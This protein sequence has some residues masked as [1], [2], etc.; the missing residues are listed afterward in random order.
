MFAIALLLPL[1]T[2]WNLFAPPNRSFKIGPKLAGVTYELPLTLSWSAIRDGS[3]QKAIA[4]RITEAFA[5]RPMLIRINNEIRYELFGEL[6]APGLVR[7]AKGHLFGQYYIDDYCSRT[8][9]M[10]ERLAADALP[11]LRD[12]RDY[13]RARGGIF[14]YMVSPSKAAHLPDYFTDR[15][16]CPSTAAD[17]AQLLP[18]Y[19]DA[20]RAGG[21]DVLDAASL[22]HAARGKYPFDLFPEGG[23]HWNEVGGALAVTSLVEEINKQAEREIVP[24][25]TFSYELSSPAKGADRELADLLNVFF[26]PL[27]YLTPK[28]KYTQPVSCAD[29]SAR[30][31]DIAIVGDSFSHLPGSILAEQNCLARL[32]VYYYGKTGLF[33]GV[34]Y[35]VLKLNLGDADLAPLRDV[36]V[37]I[38]E[39]NERFVARSGYLPMLRDILKR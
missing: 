37:L 12:I 10:G 3:L 19:T 16:R 21:I 6:E 20:L 28:V 5:F 14:I 13:Y 30:N 9:G 15:V 17:R 39:E 32:D 29:S 33:G 36:K 35:H 31:L 26:P 38:L 4:E 11:K 34:P 25:F 1:V 2:A 7:G 22:I 27:N 23:E 8:A 24:P 18:T